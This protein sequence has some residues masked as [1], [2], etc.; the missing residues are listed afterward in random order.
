MNRR[1]AINKIA[2][3]LLVATVAPLLLLP[4]KSKAASSATVNQRTISGQVQKAIVLVNDC[5]VRPVPI[6]NGWTTVRVGLRLHFTTGSISSPIMA[7]GLCAG[8]S[9]KICD[10]STSHFVG[11]I[12]NG[13]FTNN[14]PGCGAVY[15]SVPLKAYKRVGT[16]DTIGSNITGDSRYGNSADAN[17]ADRGILFIDI[18]KG[19][20]NYTINAWYMA[21]GT[22]PDVSKAIFENMLNTLQGPL[23]YDG[24]VNMVHGTDQ[25]VAVNEGTDGTLD[26]LCVY[27][28]QTAVSMEICDHGF[29][30]LA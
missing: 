1:F 30:V 10:A 20:P 17:C 27:W 25:T 26:S 29:A 19:S 16:T 22:A 15:F 5:F 14:G 28:N 18:T 4:R 8:S 11:I 24:G 9:N 21:N 23:Q 3:G 13:G 2:S 6:P 7:V 12:A